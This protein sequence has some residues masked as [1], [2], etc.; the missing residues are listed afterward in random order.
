[1]DT[2]LLYSSC[3]EYAFSNHIKVPGSSYGIP[4]WGQIVY[5]ETLPAENFLRALKTEG[6][7][8]HNN[9][10]NRLCQDAQLFLLI[11]GFL[12]MYSHSS[13]LQTDD[14]VFKVLTEFSHI[15]ISKK[16]FFKDIC[17]ALNPATAP[18]IPRTKNITNHLL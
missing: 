16:Q 14:S 6:K 3:K 15:F 4:E 9:E 1:M 13:D 2:G 18:T 17:A 10:F 12:R 8:E 11:W 5:N 7:V